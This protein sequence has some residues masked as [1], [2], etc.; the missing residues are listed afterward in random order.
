MC[1]AAPQ[2]GWGEA[3]LRGSGNLARLRGFVTLSEMPTAR[4]PYPH[5]C[6][7]PFWA[8][9][10]LLLPCPARAPAQSLCSSCCGEGQ[11]QP[12]SSPLRAAAGLYLWLWLLWTLFP[13]LFPCSTHGSQGILGWVIAVPGET[14]GISHAAVPLTSHYSQFL[15]RGEGREKDREK[16]I[17]VWLPLS[18]RLLGTWP[19]TQA[20][21]LTGNP[22]GDPWFAACTQF[23]EPHQPGLHLLVLYAA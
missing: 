20:C 2:E 10:Q 1:P 17:N 3:A 13:S 5:P 8:Q 6:A 9:P 15:E 11:T 16:N 19:A 4:Q 23:T 12:D 21:V 14:K 18:H 7:S 22:T